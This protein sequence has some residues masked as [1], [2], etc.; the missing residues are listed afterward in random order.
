MSGASGCDSGQA[1]NYIGFLVVSFGIESCFI[2]LSG[3]VIVSVGAA[4]GAA[5]GA[6]IVVVSPPSAFFSPHAATATTA[7]AIRNFRIASPLVVMT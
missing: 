4:V 7:A 2:P 5:T 6:A 3:F 1:T